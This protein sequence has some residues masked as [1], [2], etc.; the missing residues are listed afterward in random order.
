M[1]LNFVLIR[2]SLAVKFSMLLNFSEKKTAR[3]LYTDPNLS[4]DPFCS[5]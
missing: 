5:F 3:L 1:L 4:I 2:R